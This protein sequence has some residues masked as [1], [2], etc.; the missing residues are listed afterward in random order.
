MAISY[1]I[2]TT[3]IDFTLEKLGFENQI[4]QV[5]VK[6][7]VEIGKRRNMRESLQETFH[8][9]KTVYPYLLLGAG[10]GA[11]IHGA[12]PAEWISTCMGG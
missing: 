1:T 10:I 7:E 12:V 3:M 11:I 8:L 9:M 6:G 5:M 4:K 2:I